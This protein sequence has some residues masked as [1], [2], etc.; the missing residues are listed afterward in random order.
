M[1]ADA[2]ISESILN[3]VFPNSRLSG[4]AN[5]L[6]MPNLEAAN[7]SNNLLQS[8]G[9][10]LAIGPMLVGTSRP[11]HILTASVTVRG[12]INMTAVGA[13]DAQEHD[14]ARKTAG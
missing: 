1:H 9:R 11:M 2:A 4:T 13:V 3:R 6:V 12:I 8:A 10:A 5:L 7:I 14:K